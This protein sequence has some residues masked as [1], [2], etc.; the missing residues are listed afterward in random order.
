MINTVQI[1]LP[2]N[3]YWK[4]LT[5]NFNKVFDPFYGIIL[6]VCFFF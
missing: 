1:D 5:S 4:C 6:Q 2:K 3:F